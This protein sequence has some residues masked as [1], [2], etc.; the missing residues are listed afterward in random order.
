VDDLFRESCEKLEA[1]NKLNPHD[2]QILSEW[3][4]ALSEHATSK[5]RATAKTIRPLDPEVLKEGE[6]DRDGL[7]LSII[8]LY[9]ILCYLLLY[10]CF[11]DS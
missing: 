1:A 8:F 11:I 6:I 3:A 2:A 9:H 7:L 5:I 4:D 10:C